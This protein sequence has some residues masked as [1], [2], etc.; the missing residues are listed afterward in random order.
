MAMDLK[1]KFITFEGSEG[2][3][4]STQA[5]LVFEYL[6]SK[7]KPVMLLREPGGVKISEQVRGI[8]LDTANTAMGDECETLLYMAARAQLV[9]EVLIPALEAGKIVICDRFMDSTIAYQGYGNGV[10]VPTIGS[11]GRLATQGIAPVLTLLFDIDVAKGLSR[12]NVVK[13]RIEL[14]P[15]DYHQRVRQGYLAIANNEPRRV[16]VISV[17]ASKEEIFARVKSYIDAACGY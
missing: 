12:T 15:L 3:G 4:K 2:S 17:D 1:G 7:N 8:L 16:K 13:D 14:R 9:K 5:C 11:I 6:K 10:D